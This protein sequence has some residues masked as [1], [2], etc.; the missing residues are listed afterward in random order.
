[1]LFRCFRSRQ[2][3]RKAEFG[4]Q[5]HFTKERIR[6]IECYIKDNYCPSQEPGFVPSVPPDDDADA[7]SKEADFLSMRPKSPVSD[8]AAPKPD[9][10]LHLDPKASKPDSKSSID[11]FDN[12]PPLSPLGQMR[13][14]ETICPYEV[15]NLG[16]LLDN[17]DETF[18]EM[19]LRLIDEKGK[20]D[21]DV[22][23]GA[24][25]D[26][27]LFSKI[28]SNRAYNPKKTT[29]L[30]LAISLELSLEE[31]NELLRSA[32][33][34]LSM[35]QKSDVIM[36]YFLERREYDL[37]LINETLLYFGQTLLGTGVK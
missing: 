35:G 14:C 13:V 21:T 23:K 3:P 27:K 20:K 18:S 36:Q 32:G 8:Y 17:M 11:V 9:D 26:R 33:Y 15:G 16:D 34:A 29:V 5:E 4:K 22:Y 31:T 37:L 25:M 12:L 28:R 19:L 2:A 6:D 10:C 7:T 1:M 24:N 30:A